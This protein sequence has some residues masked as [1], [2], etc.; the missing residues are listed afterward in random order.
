MLRIFSRLP[1]GT[2]FTAA[3]IAAHEVVDIEVVDFEVDIVVHEVVDVEV[4]EFEVEVELDVEVALLLIV[5]PGRLLLECWLVSHLAGISLDRVRE[6]R[7]SREGRWVW[8]GCSLLIV[9]GRRKQNNGYGLYGILLS[10]ITI[11]IYCGGNRCSCQWNCNIHSL[12]QSLLGRSE[13][14]MAGDD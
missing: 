6:G 10:S 14:P 7:K 9:E 12:C 1:S 5:V 8:E 4:V 2:L 3:T 11:G 13:C